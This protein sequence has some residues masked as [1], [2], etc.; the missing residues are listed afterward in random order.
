MAI[1][2]STVISTPVPTLGHHYSNKRARNSILVKMCA[3]DHV[4]VGIRIKSYDHNKIK[5]FEDKSNGIVGYKDENGEIIC[6]GYD[7]GPRFSQQISRFTCNSSGD[8]EIIDLLQRC[9]LH[10]SDETEFKTAEA[11]LAGNKDY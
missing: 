8:A 7:E 4:P 10:A 1:R 2:S 6:E 9:W 3:N 11:E 5:V